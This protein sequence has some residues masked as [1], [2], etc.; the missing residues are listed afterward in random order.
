VSFQVSTIL[1]MRL[2]SHRRIVLR[3]AEHQDLPIKANGG[4]D[5]QVRSIYWRS[6]IMMRKYAIAGLA[7]IA[8]F[9]TSAFAAS[10]ALDSGTLQV[11]QDSSVKCTNGT[12]TTTYTTNRDTT[13][14]WVG[15]VYVNF[16]SD[17]CDGMFVVLTGKDTAGAALFD[18]N[19]HVIGHTATFDIPDGQLDA[20][21]VGGFM[22]LVRD[23]VA[24]DTE[25]WNSLPGGH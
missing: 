6:F 5:L 21:D 14:S 4:T 13:K 17:A 25:P 16:P 18:A 3:G 1:T 11:G 15:D 9:S 19:S 20:A 10:L 23:K 7:A 22:V 8:A 24:S 2:E 12:A